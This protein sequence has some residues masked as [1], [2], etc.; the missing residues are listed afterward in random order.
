MR[1]MA[2][3]NQQ[4][5]TLGVV[6]AGGKGNRFTGDVPKQ[7]LEL[8]G[9]PVFLHSVLAFQAS[10]RIDGITVVVP[11]GYESEVKELLS[12]H[13]VTKTVAVTCGG[14]ERQDSVKSA[15]NV[16]LQGRFD[17]V[18]LHDAARPLLSVEVIARLCDALETNR[19]ATAALPVTDT[20]AVTENGETIAAVPDRRTLWQI[21]TPQGFCLYTL[22]EAYARLSPAVL[23]ACTDDCGVVRAFLPDESAALVEG[24]RKLQ[25][26]TY[27]EDLAVLTA[28]VG[29]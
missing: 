26:L 11:A 20:V 16:G 25:K 14:A 22:A 27:P 2:E 1:C 29:E 17:R 8:A 3:N 18:L 4:K 24:D 28:L 21:Q 7:F 23:A 15:L 6:L 12:R 10:D 13:G 5:K 9:K 19:A